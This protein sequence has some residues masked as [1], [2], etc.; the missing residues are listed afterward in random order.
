M[1]HPNHFG[2]ARV[3]PVRNE[4]RG[5][6]RRRRHAEA[7]GHLLHCARDGVRA[8]GLFLSDIG[9]RQGVH[10]TSVGELIF[11]RLGVT[12]E[13]L[14]QTSAPAIFDDFDTS[15]WNSRQRLQILFFDYLRCENDEESLNSCRPKNTK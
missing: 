8:A 2:R 12:G 1:N 5:D 14:Y 11:A 13:L 7:Q 6:Q 3:I 15:E 10:A 4:K 9:K